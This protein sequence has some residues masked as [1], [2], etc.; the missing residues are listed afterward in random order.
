MYIAIYIKIT[1]TGVM[2]ILGKWV[3]NGIFFLVLKDYQEQNMKVGPWRKLVSQSSFLRNGWR[4]A[5]KEEASK[6]LR[7]SSASSQTI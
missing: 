4:Y 1:D 5:E 6:P 2:D 3:K 7:A